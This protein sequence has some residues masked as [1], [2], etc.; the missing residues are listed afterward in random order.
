MPRLKGRTRDMDTA[1]GKNADEI[2]R[3]QAQIRKCLAKGYRTQA[4][5]LIKRLDEI[6]D[7]KGD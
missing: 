3:L 2:Q 1:I 4:K 6:K 5:P 7:R